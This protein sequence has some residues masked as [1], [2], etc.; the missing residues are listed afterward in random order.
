LIGAIEFFTQEFDRRAGVRCEINQYGSVGPG[1]NLD[2]EQSTAVFRIFQEI[3]LNVR[4]H[5]RATR[6][7]I[8]L[9]GEDGYF[10][11]EVRDNGKGMPRDQLKELEGLGILGMRER[12]L[13]FGGTVSIESEPGRGTRVEVRIPSVEAPEG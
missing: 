3:L 10:I 1:S 8:D 4:R 6:V 9:R 13:V 7:W 11:L 2:P 5:A 12:A